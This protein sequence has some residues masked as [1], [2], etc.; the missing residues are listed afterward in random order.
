MDDGKQI[1]LHVPMR[2]GADDLHER[3]FHASFA[4]FGDDPDRTKYDYAAPQ[5][6]AFVDR[7]GIVMLVGCSWSHA[8]WS[9]YGSE[10]VIVAQRAILGA[11]DYRFPVI[12]AMRTEISGLSDWLG[13]SGV[14]VQVER[15]A[16]GRAQS[17]SIASR[18]GEHIALSRR[19]N[20]SAEATWRERFVTDGSGI[21]APAQVKTQVTRAKPWDDHADLHRAFLGLVEISA[22][23]R[24]GFRSMH[25]RRDDD[26]ERAAAGNVIGPRWSL[27]RSY[28]RDH[29]EAPEPSDPRRFLFRYADVGATGVREWLSVRKVFQRGVQQ[30]HAM[31]HQPGM[32]LE[33]QQANVGAALEAIGYI[34]ALEAGKSPTSSSRESYAA[35][36]ERLRE[37]IP[38]RVLDQ[39][40]PERSRAAFMAAK[41]VDAPAPPLDVQVRAVGENIL[42]YR[43]WLA[44]RLGATDQQL[45]RLI[46]I[47]P[48]VRRYGLTI[49][50]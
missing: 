3:W 19:L 40:W 39:D 46:A 11:R 33:V 47:D 30:M 6:V 1:T 15:D 38:E 7:H 5:T 20:L 9:S 32:F 35:R 21:E 44:R 25:V 27:V 43:Y 2:P 8:A 28:E 36:L 29:Q 16:K 4:E 37:L 26:P 41:H 48:V 22:W 10:G 50:D 34:L 17:I 14:D 31:L 42:A 49:A 18:R 13:L 45:L 12:N 23:D 24:I